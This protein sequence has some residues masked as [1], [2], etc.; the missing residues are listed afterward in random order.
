VCVCVCVCVR[1]CVRACVCACARVC[2]CVCVCV[3]NMTVQEA[4]YSRAVQRVT[5]GVA[6]RAYARMSPHAV[7]SEEVVRHHMPPRCEKFI[8]L[9]IVKKGTRRKAVGASSVRT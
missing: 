1:A 3:I 5:Q 8:I 7:D 9:L 6:L 2:V 4:V